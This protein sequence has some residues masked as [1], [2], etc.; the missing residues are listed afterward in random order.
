MMTAARL[1]ERS[2]RANSQFERPSAT[3][4]MRFS[5]QLLCLP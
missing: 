1:P 5:S 2:E 4:R 3:G